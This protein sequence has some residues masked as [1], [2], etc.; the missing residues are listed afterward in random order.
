MEN[1][2][3]NGEISMVTPHLMFSIKKFVVYNLKNEQVSPMMKDDHRIIWRKQSRK[4]NFKEDEIP[5]MNK[6]T[7]Y[8]WIQRKILDYDNNLYRCFSNFVLTWF[9]VL[10]ETVGQSRLWYIEEVASIIVFLAKRTGSF[11]K[12]CCQAQSS[13]F[14][15]DTLRRWKFIISWIVRWCNC[16]CHYHIQTCK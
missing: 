7:S 12:A 8:M 13:D 5:F 14:W 10:L 3:L 6:N 9:T 2:C 1:I 11:V 16:S 4:F 15:F